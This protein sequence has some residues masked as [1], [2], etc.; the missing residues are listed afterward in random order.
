MP[1]TDVAPVD[2]IY[3]A[4]A[5]APAVPLYVEPTPNPKNNLIPTPLLVTHVPAVSPGIVMLI[6]VQVFAEEIVYV[7]GYE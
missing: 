7:N 5:Q 2:E 3:C 6:C 4:P 1:T